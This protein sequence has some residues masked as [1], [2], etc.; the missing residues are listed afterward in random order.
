MGGVV[1]DGDEGGAL[2]QGQLVHRLAKVFLR[3]R[4]HAIAAVA[5]IDDVE[6]PLDGLVLGVG[7][8][9]LQRLEDL[10]HLPP[11]RGLI[12]AGEVL[13]ELLG[14]GAAALDLLPGEHIGHRRRRP[15]PV[16]PVVLAEPLVLDG[17]GGVDEVVGHILQVR[18]HPV[19][20]GVEGLVG[21]IVV[22]LA[23]VVVQVGGQVGVGGQQGGAGLLHLRHDHV[24]YVDRGVASHDGAGGHKDQQQGAKDDAQALEE[25]AR[26][27]GRL[28]LFR[29]CICQNGNTS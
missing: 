26:L 28:I 21:H 14:D 18:P 19:L 27:G 29:F 25:A 22:R 12:V 7:L 11:H 17:D 2:G 13:D 5:Q 16:H 9:E 24:V 15:H 8:V 23:V 4:G 10:Q 20:R 1:G 6:I 3:R